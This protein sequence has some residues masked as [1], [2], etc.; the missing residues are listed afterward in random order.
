MAKII[1]KMA[2]V[3]DSMISSGMR[4]SHQGEVWADIDAKLARLKSSSATS[5]MSDIFEQQAAHLEEYV[6]SFPPVD[7]QAGAVFVING[8]MVGFDLFDSP[9]TYRKLLP[10]LLRSYSLDALDKMA[11]ISSQAGMPP[12]PHINEV[13]AFLKSLSECEVREFPAV[14]DG[15]DIRLTKAGL[16]AAA[17]SVDNHII[18]LSAFAIN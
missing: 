1:E 15:Q 5:A 2:Q 13:E 16:A 8:R 7:A 12:V 9:E 14:G 4:S 18:H 11:T 17:L 3:T 6:R 10:K